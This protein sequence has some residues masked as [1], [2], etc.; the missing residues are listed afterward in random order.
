FTNN[1]A[2][3]TFTGETL[4]TFSEYLSQAQ[5]AL[6]G[7]ED[8]QLAYRVNRL[9][10]TPTTNGGTMGQI[11][12]VGDPLFVDDPRH[13]VPDLPAGVRL[14]DDFVCDGFGCAPVIDLNSNGSILDEAE[15]RTLANAKNFDGSATPGLI[16]INT[17]P[18]EVLRCMPHMMRL[19]HET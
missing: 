14:L 8:P 13:A 15:G 16:N 12:G 4:M 1:T 3:G 19:V 7:Y 18:L 2:A 6:T 17:A 10:L 9:L 11:I 5:A